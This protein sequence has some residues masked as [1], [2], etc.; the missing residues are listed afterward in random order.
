MFFL[1]YESDGQTAS[2]RDIA[3]ARLQR[4][5]CQMRNARISVMAE[6]AAPLNVLALAGHAQ[7]AAP[8]M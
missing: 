6:G 2:L 3:A 8:S 1:G 7:R 5:A 4:P